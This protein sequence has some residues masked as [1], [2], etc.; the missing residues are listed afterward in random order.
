[1]YLAANVVPSARAIVK[2]RFAKRY[3]HPALDAKLSKQ[4]FL[5]EVRSMVKAAKSGIDVPGL[6]FVDK[7]EMVRAAL[8]ARCALN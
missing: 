4:R 5:G 3:R 7:N 8:C 1:M 2:E 6:Y